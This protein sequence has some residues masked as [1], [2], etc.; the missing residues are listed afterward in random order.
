MRTA[1]YRIHYGF[2]FIYKSIESVYNW[3]P[4]TENLEISENYAHTIKRAYLAKEN[5]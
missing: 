5:K 4:A 3:T 2:E 1:L